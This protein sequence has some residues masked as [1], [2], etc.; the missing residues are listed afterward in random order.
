MTETGRW[1]GSA[2]L[3]LPLACAAHLFFCAHSHVAWAEERVRSI[4]APEMDWA[5]GRRSVEAELRASGYETVDAE[6]VAVEPSGLLAELRAP[7]EEEVVAS[8]TV[9]R[10]GRTGI[11]Y[12][13]LARK[14]RIFRVVAS[15]EEPA[16]A[17]HVLSLRVAELVTLQHEASFED[18]DIVPP[19]K[20]PDDDVPSTRHPW[21]IFFGVGSSH[22]FGLIRPSVTLH[23]A[24]SYEVL[25][26]FDVELGGGLSL[27]RGS[28]AFESGEVTYGEQ[29]LALRFLVGTDIGDRFTWRVGSA[30]G[31][32]CL[33]IQALDRLNETSTE[34]RVCAL[35]AGI[36]ARGSVRFERMSLWFSA[37]PALLL[38]SVEIF[39]ETTEVASLGRPWLGLSGGLSWRL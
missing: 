39:D 28:E 1:L 30:L 15:N 13:W 16:I 20:K 24:L 12:V 11:A 14:N 34:R 26:I 33:E 4:R 32:H 25:P 5:Q 38:P 36:A 22:S 21:Q 35:S 9:V 17:A 3:A 37:E 10:L 2:L 8:V 19:E 23:P 7:G 6:S 18:A 27:R 31:P 29:R